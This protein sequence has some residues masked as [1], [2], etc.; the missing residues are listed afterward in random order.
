MAA[1]LVSS[2]GTSS[3][4]RR[5]STFR[6]Q[7]CRHGTRGAGIYLNGVKNL[8]QRVL[9]GAHNW[10]ITHPREGLCVLGN[11]PRLVNK[12]RHHLKSLR[13]FPDLC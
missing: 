12:R 13:F 7:D 8:P 4:N 5:E 9:R 3:S 11:P 1:S 2:G 10:R 6:I